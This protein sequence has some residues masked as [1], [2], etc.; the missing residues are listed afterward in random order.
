MAVLFR[1]KSQVMVDGGFVYMDIDNDGIPYNP[2]YEL[3]SYGRMDLEDRADELVYAF[4]KVKDI[5]ALL[6]SG[7]I[8]Q[9]RQGPWCKYCPAQPTCPAKWSMIR[10]AMGELRPLES[11][12]E[13]MT[14]EKC[15]EAWAWIKEIERFAKAAEK[16]LKDR[17]HAAGSIPLPNG[18]HLVLEHRNGRESLDKKKTFALL[19]E[20]IGMLVEN[21]AVDEDLQK[22]L[23]SRR[24]GLITLGNS[25]TQT[26]ERKQ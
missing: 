25:Y 6:K 26:A 17:L 10:A 4:N 18:K 13:A 14:L 8:P 9:L 23:L 7:G 11:M 1:N 12:V 5:A 20:L 19:D 16:T 15:G 24:G 22:Q 21:G 3:Y 2:K